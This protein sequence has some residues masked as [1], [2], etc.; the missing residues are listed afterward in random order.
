M[1]EKKFHLSTPRSLIQ[2]KRE[3]GNITITM[4]SRAPDRDAR[5]GSLVAAG[6]LAAN[7]QKGKQREQIIFQRLLAL[8]RRRRQITAALG[9]PPPK[10]KIGEKKEEKQRGSGKLK[11]KQTEKISRSRSRSLQWKQKFSTTATSPIE[12]DTPP[13][14]RF[15]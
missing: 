9:Q 15:F 7:S 8:P 1:L 5:G 11:K 2:R 10:Q 3:R 14:L 6:R 13:P 4:L 12:S